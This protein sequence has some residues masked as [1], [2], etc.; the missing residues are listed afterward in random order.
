MR[1]A[2]RSVGVTRPDQIE[3]LTLGTLHIASGGTEIRLTP[4]EYKLLT[5]LAQHAGNI[6]THRQLLA[7]VCSARAE[8]LAEH[9][10]YPLGTGTQGSGQVS[11]YG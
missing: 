8:A 6:V 2:L 10:S 11:T 3:P 7:Q 1:A 4:I 5:T 9:V